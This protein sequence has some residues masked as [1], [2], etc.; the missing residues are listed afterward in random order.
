MSLKRN[1]TALTLLFSLA[2]AAEPNIP[3]MVQNKYSPSP[4]AVQWANRGVELANQGDYEAAVDALYEAWKLSPEKTNSFAINLSSAY[5]NLGKQLADAGK[6]DAAMGALRKAVFFQEENKIPAGNLDLLLKRKGLNPE[7]FKTRLTEAQRLRGN[8]NLDESVAEYLK[9]ISLAKTG[10]PDSLKAKLELAQVYQV[11]YTKY[12]LTPVGQARFEKMYSLVQD[13]IKANPK[14]AKPFI[15]LGRAY[16]SAEKLPEGI[17]AFETALKI[18]PTEKQAQDGLV[19]AWRKVLEIAPNEVANML[20][21]A[22]A[23]LRTGN[24]DEAGR[25][26]QKAKSLD[27]KNPEIDKMLANS[28]QSE[29][30]AELYRVAERAFEAQKAGKFDEAIDL[31]QI[32]IKGLPPT[33]ETSNIYYNLGLAYQAKGRTQDSLNAFNQALKFNPTNDNAKRAIQAINQQALAAKNDRIKKAVSLQS[34]GKVNEAIA[35]YQEILKESPNDAQVHFN[36]GTAF[37]EAGVYQQALIEYRTAAKLDPKNSEFSSA[38]SALQE[39]INS[40]AFQAAQATNVLKEAVTLQQAGKTAQA[41]AKYQEAIKLDPKN[42][43]THFN[44]ATAFHASNRNKE[45]LASYKEAYRLDPVGYPE[46]NYFIG[47]LMEYSSSPSE[48]VGYYKR[49]LE[50]Q[51]KAEYSGQAEERIKLLSGK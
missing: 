16:L 19:G 1:L 42:A 23:L 43:Q 20:G 50:D 46:A 48:A 11:I 30:E 17:D 38:V 44:L 10:S 8:G 34:S 27:P 39:A 47:N 9:A 35:L 29:K 7:D 33:P 6:L 22:G 51:P 49:Y 36:L 3:G 32:A 2:A 12:I 25:L 45:A 40:G 24:A 18:N 13:L 37:Q 26:L 41:I 31:Y 28:K 14:D 4:V 15:L 21:L 5:N